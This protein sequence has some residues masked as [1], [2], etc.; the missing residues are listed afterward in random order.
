M[1]D[2]LEQERI[3]PIVANPEAVDVVHAGCGNRTLRSVVAGAV[4]LAFRLQQNQ[5]IQRWFKLLG[6]LMLPMVMLIIA[7]RLTALR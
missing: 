7:Q 6:W 3:L 1:Y 5:L 4:W 2:R